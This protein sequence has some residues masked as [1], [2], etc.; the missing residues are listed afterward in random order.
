MKVNNLAIIVAVGRDGA[1]G[2]GNDLVWRISADMKRFKTL[3]MGHPVI[4]GRKTWE[5]LPK[6]LPGR[7]NIV[8]T[9]NA[10]YKADGAVVVS[11]LE[12][13]LGKVGS[14]ETSFIIGG[15]QIYGEALRY[16]DRLY[17]TLIDA[18]CKD[19]DV[20]FP[21]S[22]ATGVMGDWTLEAASEVFHDEKLD[23]DYR[24]LD[25]CRSETKESI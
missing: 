13:A 1:I 3:T 9:R 19:A 16:A 17:L 15:A 22:P 4:M 14:G 6:A 12:E 2:R 23:V 11:S 8:I 5:S 7:L 10:D 25:Y 21:P 24:F 20:W 18:D